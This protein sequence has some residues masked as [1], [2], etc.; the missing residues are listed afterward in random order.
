MK[1]S[2]SLLMA[3][4]A[5]AGLC[6]VSAAHADN[7]YQPYYYVPNPP[8]PGA[9]APLSPISHTIQRVTGGIVDA[10]RSVSNAAT[11]AAGG[12][13]DV[14]HDIAASDTMRDTTAAVVDAQHDVATGTAPFFTKLADKQHAIGE[15]SR[16]TG[17]VPGFNVPDAPRE[18]GLDWGLRTESG[19]DGGLSLSNYHYREPAPDVSLA[20][21][22]GSI[23]AQFTGR[24]FR[25]YFVTGDVR[26]AVGASDYSGSGHATNNFE[27]LYDIRGL[28]GRDVVVNS[29]Y[30][31]SPFTGVGVRSFYSDDR[32]KSSTGASGYRRN[33]VLYYLPVG[34]TQRVLFTPES[35]VRAT[36]EYDYAFYGLQTS[37]L[38]DV[39]GGYP[40][41]DNPQHFGNGYRAELMYE[42][43]HWGVGPFANYWAIADSEMN[44]SC[45]TAICFTGHEPHNNTLEVGLR[46]KFHMWDW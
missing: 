19:I 29:F 8:P 32:G 39:P 37:Y 27:R 5:F 44:T 42:T 43:P 40:N 41:I 10:E 26:F 20:G 9:E 7:G 38:S 16:I 34:L 28:V 31:L 22:K 12:L 46:A 23:D 6:A 4:V 18:V 33:N 11:S 30:S 25:D 2:R 17:N 35:R 36:V 3:G 13:A 24:F 15:R 1:K 45:G 21:F 14:Q